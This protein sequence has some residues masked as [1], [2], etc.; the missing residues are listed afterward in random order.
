MREHAKAKIFP[1][2]LELVCRHCKYRLFEVAL[3][4]ANLEIYVRCGGCR[5]PFR[6]GA[7]I[8]I[9]DIGAWQ[10]SG[11]LILPPEKP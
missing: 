6:T 4:Q 1:D 3:V 7:K 9:K 5:K 11:G 10:P 2:A 8:E